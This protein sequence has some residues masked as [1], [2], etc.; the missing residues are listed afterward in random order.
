MHYCHNLDLSIS[1][2]F[3]FKGKAS[4][5]NELGSLLG[6]TRAEGQDLHCWKDHPERRKLRLPRREVRQEGPS[7]FLPEP[8]TWAPQQPH[9]QK[10]WGPGCAEGVCFFSV[11]A[12]LTSFVLARLSLNKTMPLIW[13]AQCFHGFFCFC[14]CDSILQSSFYI[15]KIN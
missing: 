4:T 2:L 8:K 1:T 15:W 12:H 11:W 13:A 6:H 7:N 14:L 5:F 3:F 9:K 10:P